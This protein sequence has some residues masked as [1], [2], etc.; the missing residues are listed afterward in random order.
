MQHS[1]IAVVTIGQAPRKDMAEDIQ[2]LREAG[3]HVHEFGVLDSLSSE[4]IA[5]L[6]P[7]LEDS[8]V[9]VTLLTNG[10]Q[11]KL[12][13]QKLMPYIQSCIDDLHEFTWILLMCTG[14]FTNKLSYKNLLLPDRMMT[15]LVKG[16]HTELAIG[17]IGPE[18]EQH[19]T[20]AEKWQKAQFDVTFSASSP[21]HFDNQHLLTK[22]QQLEEQG[23]DLLILDCMG[24]STTMKNMI[25]DQ[26]TIPIIVP[27]EAVF[28]ILKAIC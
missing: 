25:K 21:Y 12:S 27:R 4:E 22:A 13:K 19:R 14:D 2:Q 16:L 15:N 20:V 26:L 6:S 28:T 3:L 10:R 7:S 23:A 9:L 11:V 17:L 18:P 1:K 8:D 24:Y 5:T